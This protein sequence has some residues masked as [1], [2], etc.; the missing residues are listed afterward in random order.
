MLDLVDIDAPS[1]WPARLLAAV[2]GP[3]F[4][5]DIHDWRGLLEGRWLLTYHATRLLP[6]EVDAIR[7]E[8]L[9]ALTPGLLDRRIEEAHRL[10][11]LTQGETDI[12]RSSNVFSQNRLQHREA[13][14]LPRGLQDVGQA[15][16]LS[17]LNLVPCSLVEPIERGADVVGDG[18]FGGE[19]VVAG[20]DLDGAVAA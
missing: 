5:P 15:E 9:Q 19:G 2:S 7:A 12:M 20:V 16:D 17:W 8:G 11:Y 3:G 14:A 10:G 13:A 1:T 6:H 18:L 4:D